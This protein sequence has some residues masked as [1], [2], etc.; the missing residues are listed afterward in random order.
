M[1]GSGAVS[2]SGEFGLIGVDCLDTDGVKLDGG[3]FELTFDETAYTEKSVTFIPVPGTVSIQ[4]YIYKDANIGG[5]AY[6]DDL[7]II[8]TSPPVTNN[9]IANPSFE[10]DLTDWTNW[11]E[12]AL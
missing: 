8:P 6:I 5:N 1:S 4:L 10:S 11:E 9:L 7:S 3:N 2:A 12:P